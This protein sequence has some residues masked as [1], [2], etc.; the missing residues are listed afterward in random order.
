MGNINTY[1]NVDSS[2]VSATEREYL[3]AAK[4]HTDKSAQLKTA[5]P[6]SPCF[7]YNMI[8]L[9]EGVRYDNQR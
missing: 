9:I 2:G 7:W 3:R 1:G 4:R 8:M 5:L 6:P